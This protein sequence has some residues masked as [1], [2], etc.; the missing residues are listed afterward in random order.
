[1]VLTHRC[2]TIAAIVGRI[3]GSYGSWDFG[4]ALLAGSGTMCLRVCLLALGFSYPCLS[5]AVWLATEQHF[6]DGIDVHGWG[7]WSWVLVVYGE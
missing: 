1:M 2:G 4:V 5:L 3:A 6:V 7:N